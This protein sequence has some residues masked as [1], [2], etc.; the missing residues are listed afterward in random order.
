LVID[1]SGDI[2]QKGAPNDSM[3]DFM[4]NQHHSFNGVAIFL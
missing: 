1:Q 2:Y 3:A 4:G